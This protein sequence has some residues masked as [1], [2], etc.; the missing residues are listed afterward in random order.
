MNYGHPLQFGTF[1]TPSNRASEQVVALAR[2]SEELGYDLVTFQDHPYQPAFLDTWTLMTWVAAQTE[3]IHVAPNVLNLPLRPPAVLARAAASLDLLSGGRLDLALGAGAFWD[4]IKA[5]GARQLTAGE[6][7]D[8]LSEAIDILRSVWDVADR[9]H[10]RI[11]GKYYQINGMR[12]GPLPAHTIPIWIGA[13]KPRMLRLVG[14]KGDGW[15]PSLGYIKPEEIHAANQ[16]ID[17]AARDAGRD[18]RE[19]RRM[20]NISG[21]FSAQRGG[22]LNGT[23]QQWVDDL[24][25]LV[26]DEGMSTFILMG[27]DS[28]TLEQF[29]REVMP[30]LREAAE[31][32]LPELSSGERIRS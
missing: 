28:R 23:S 14:Q 18:P 9:S 7:V 12:R 25:P 1:I 16:I 32:K 2:L 19:I 30:A 4:G 21:Q 6:A 31:R 27:D 8:A 26:I 3:R 5:M 24:L 29:A 13:Y 17:E 10:L 11:D 22:F 15:L 20:L